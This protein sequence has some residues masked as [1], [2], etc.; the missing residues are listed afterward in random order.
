MVVLAYADV[1]RCAS[2]HAMTK[3]LAWRNPQGSEEGWLQRHQRIENVREHTKKIISTEIGLGILTVT[4]AVETVAYSV[5]TLASLVLYPVTDRPCIF[6]AKLL[7]S[8]SFTIIWGIADAILYN[9]FF[10]NVMTQESFARYWAANFNPTPIEMYRFND[11][12][13][14]ADWGRQHGRGNVNNGLLGPILIEGLNT[15]KLIDQGANFIQQDVL[16]GASKQ[17]LE[18]FDGMDPSIFMFILTKAVYIYA[19]GAKKAD[20]I[21]SFFKLETKNLILTLRQQELNSEET[22]KEL[23]RLVRDPT[24]FETAPQGDYAQDFFNRLRKVAF[25]ELQNSLLCS[26]CWAKSAEQ[27]RKAATE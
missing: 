15:Q 20:E 14:V 9:P 13:Y 8:S 3:L 26:R 10:I 2:S 17:T 16:A 4:S 25:G 18:L 5:L 21:P 23:E 22:A 7:Q 6:F 27:L 19:V 11:R 24:E 12:M 1:T